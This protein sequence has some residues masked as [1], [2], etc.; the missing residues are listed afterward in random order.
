MTLGAIVFS[1]LNHES[2]I[3]PQGDATLRGKTMLSSKF[4]P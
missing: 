4:R 1:F 2:A 3:M